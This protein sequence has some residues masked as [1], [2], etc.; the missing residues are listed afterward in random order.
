[1]KNAH[2][3][4]SFT[5]GSQIFMHALRMIEQGAKAVFLA[6]IAITG[7]WFLGQ[8]CFRLKWY[9]LYHFLFERLATMKLE[10]RNYI[11]NGITIS[12]YDFD[13]K[14]IKT[15][16]ATQYKNMV[17]HSGVGARLTNFGHWLLNEAWLQF[18]LIFTTSVIIT[19]AFFVLHGKNS[20]TKSKTRGGDLVGPDKLISSINKEN[21]A[22]N[23]CIAE[24]PLVKDSERQHILITGTTGTGKTNLLH[25]LIPQIR[26]RGEKAIIVDLNGT[27]VRSY[28]S[29]ND[30]LLNP[31]DKRSLNWNPWVDC[32]RIYDYDSLAKALVG[33]SAHRDPFW[34]NSA[35]KIIAEALQ[36]FKPSQNLQEMLRILNVSTLTE[37]SN[38]FANTPVAAITSKE[39]DKT[40]SSIRA[41]INDKIKPL[42]YL[43]NQD[44]SN[45]FSLK[46]YVANEDI[47]GWLFISALPEQR[48]S[49]LPLIA[50][51]LE[52]L[53]C[54]LMQREPGANNANL[55][56]IM[57]ELP[58]FGKI[59]SLKTSLAEARQ[60]GGCIVSGIQN[61]HQLMHI[62][63]YNEALDL[64]DQFNT[65]FIFR[66]GDPKTAQIVASMLGEQETREDKESL[67]Y[68]ASPM[69]DGVNINTIERRQQLVLPT[70][71]M[72]LPNLTC[73][74]KL[75]GNWPVTKLVMKYHTRSVHAQR[76]LKKDDL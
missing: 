2:P 67:S 27:F 71:V 57:D 72:T 23:I 68:G 4:S 18:F 48:S 50:S 64:L 36:R 15:F 22:S 41:T 44:S 31:F 74:A 70:E 21:K 30:F 43:N 28:F 69:R 47:S 60:Y 73:Y 26:A 75:A 54:G 42:I 32:N 34:D 14:T 61:I 55:W 56:F 12:I 33:E 52:I 24:L 11:P 8:C 63:G 46:E 25:E 6:S 20:M 19:Y 65:K 16:D 76:F 35:I 51:W 13:E 7:S 3:M 10:F 40:T 62:Y 37:Y 38:F 59:P 66:V 58:A 17:W 45:F 29:K 9:D 5:R 49:L 53:L 1:M 39:G